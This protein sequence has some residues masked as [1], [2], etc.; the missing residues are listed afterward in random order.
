MTKPSLSSSVLV[1]TDLDNNI[2]RTEMT[3]SSL[4]SCVLVM[5]DLDI[6]NKGSRPS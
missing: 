3:R 2:I 6:T 4:N 1:I 5:T